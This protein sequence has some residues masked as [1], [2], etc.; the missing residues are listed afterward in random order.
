MKNLYFLIISLCICLG[1]TSSNV[2]AQNKIT[3]QFHPDSWE[4]KAVKHEFKDYKGKHALY[5]E[6]GRALLKNSN[7][8][9]GII[10]YDVSFEKGR[11]FIGVHFRI[12]DSINY[13]EYYLR[14]HQSGNP[15]AMQYTPVFN[16]TAGWQLYYGEGHSTS[17]HFNFEEWMHIRLV[18]A[19]NKMDIF[20]NDMS[21]PILHVHDLKM[22]TIKGGL[23]FNT[24]L[25][26]AYFA[27][28]TYQPMDNPNL[29]SSME[30]LPESDKGTI[31]QWKVSSPFSKNQLSKVNNLK[32][33]PLSKKIEWEILSTEYTGTLNLSKLSQVSKETNT[34]LV[35]A[36]I[37]SEKNQ[38]KRLD[39]GFSDVATVF[40]NDKIIYSGQRKFRSRDYRYLGT[41]GYFDS[42]FLHLKKGKNEITF[43]ITENF[44]GWGLKAKLEN[45]E[46]VSLEKN[47]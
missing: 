46:G 29:M 25:G 34:V 4:I 10:D 24:L 2:T 9:N 14:A 17:Y 40:V 43:A 28:L 5:L 21:Q 32:D 36:V 39:F 7:F 20:I 42:I 33:F 35:K 23:G 6:N 38:I 45:L 13:E 41:I 31:L 22:E 3:A 11:K 1:F 16:G 19:N 47:R 37:I 27:N 12:Q 18:I 30:K 44:G 8:K 26:G 15:D